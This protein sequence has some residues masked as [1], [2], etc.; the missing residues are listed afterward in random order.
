MVQSTLG[1]VANGRG[2]ARSLV[3]RRIE[4]GFIE[5]GRLVEALEENHERMRRAHK[6]RAQ[7]SG[8]VA[9][10]GFKRV[11]QRKRFGR[12]HPVE[13]ATKVDGVLTQHFGDAVHDL[14]AALFIEVGVPSVH[15]QGKNVGH[16]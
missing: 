12:A 1:L 15:A 4:T 5:S 13:I 11:E 9:E 14:K 16:L 2:D 3:N 7:K 8:K 10:V 6:V